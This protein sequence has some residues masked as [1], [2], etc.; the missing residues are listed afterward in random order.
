MD[1]ST[2][3]LQTRMVNALV[4]HWALVAALAIIAKWGFPW[5]LKEHGTKMVVNALGSEEGAAKIKEVLT[6][7]F[8]NGGGDRI[9]SIVRDENAMQTELHKNETTKIVEG[10]LRRHE[11]DEERRFRGALEEF[12]SEITDRYD[13]SR[14]PNRPRRSAPRRR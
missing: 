4:D 5:A 14:R 9:R 1:T 12:E 13:L 6:N 3:D 2:L 11:E 7:H 10:Q 8:N